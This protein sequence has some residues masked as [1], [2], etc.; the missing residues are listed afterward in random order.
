MYTCDMEEYLTRRDDYLDERELLVITR[1]ILVTQKE[2]EVLNK[3]VLVMKRELECNQLEEHLSHMF[4]VL[5]RILKQNK[6]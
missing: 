4:T 6:K 2:N 1:E 5:L 3:H